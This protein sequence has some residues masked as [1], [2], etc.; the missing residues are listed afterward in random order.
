M[1]YASILLILVW[2]IAII[3]PI[4][5][6]MTDKIRIISD[7]KINKLEKA[8]DNNLIKTIKI[9]ILGSVLNSN[10]V[11]ISA[12]WYTSGIHIWNGAAPN[13]NAKLTNIKVNENIN[14]TLYKSKLAESVC[15]FLIKS[16]ISVNA[17]VPVKP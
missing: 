14:P 5:I 13:L 10:V 1:E 4:K 2:A 3:F 7:Q 11:G 12:P 15:I 8:L 9:A 17:K 16:K 6:E